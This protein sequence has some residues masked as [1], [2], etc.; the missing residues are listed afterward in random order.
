VGYTSAS[1]FSR[2]YRRMFEV[3]PASDRVE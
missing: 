1:Q 2:E 3:S